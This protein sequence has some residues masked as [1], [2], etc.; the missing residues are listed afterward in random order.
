MGTWGSSC[1]KT[2]KDVSLLVERGAVKECMSREGKGHNCHLQSGEANLLG[3]K[4]R[5]TRQS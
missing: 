1:L 4:S 5:M 3:I 2:M